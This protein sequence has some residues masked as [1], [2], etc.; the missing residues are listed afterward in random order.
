MP[1]RAVSAARPWARPGFAARWRARPPIARRVRSALATAAAASCA[2]LALAACGTAQPQAPS[3]QAARLSSALSGIA[4]ACG[5]SYQAHAF[6]AR[7]PVLGALEAKARGHARL[8]AAV[9]REDPAWLFKGKT[10][11]ELVPLAISYLRECHLAGAAS[12]LARASAR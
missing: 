12:A 2:A 11:G 6:Q 9:Y 4:Q 8:L 5:E 7:P 10:I 1:D 3:A